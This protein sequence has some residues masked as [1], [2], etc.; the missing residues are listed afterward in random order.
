VQRKLKWPLLIWS[1]WLG[2]MLWIAYA[3]AQ[4]YTAPL[5]PALW[6]VYYNDQIISP[7][8]QPDGGLLFSF[9]QTVW[10]GTPGTPGSDCG[11]NVGALL[12]NYP[13]KPASLSGTLTATFRIATQP[14]DPTIPVSFDWQ[15]ESSNTCSGTA[16]AANTRFY[17]QNTNLSQE[18]GRWYATTTYVLQ[19]T[20]GIAT[21]SVPLQPQNFTNIF[22][23]SA[24]SSNKLTNAFF[25]TLAGAN[26]FG[27]VYGGGFFAGHGVSVSQGS[28]TFELESLVT[29]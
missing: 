16:C 25:K 27:L 19:D 4:G 5:D 12:I 14:A 29:Q 10:C 15:T 17:I 3:R 23:E 2:V 18:T 28:A 9:P 13:K 6:S 26:R 24:A 7:A 8:L 1:I 20:A 22:G 11:E 21:L